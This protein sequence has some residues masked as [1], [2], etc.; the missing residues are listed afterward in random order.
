VTGIDVDIDA[1]V[2]ARAR[3]PIDPRIRQR[4]IAVQRDEGRR[5]LRALLW[6][7]GIAAVGIAAWGVTRSPL[8][9]VDTVVVRGGVHTTEADVVIASKLGRHPPM[10][11]VEPS[12]VAA[13]VEGLPWVQRARVELDWP[14][15]VKVTLL[16]RSPLAVVPA[17]PDKWVLL[18]PSGRVLADEPSAPPDLT[19]IETPKA[20]GPPAT[21]AAAPVRAALGIVETLPEPLAGRVPVVRVRD[22]DT[23]ELAL[24]NRVSVLLGPAG[25]DVREKLVALTTLVQKANLSRVAVIDVRV[26]TAPVLT[27]R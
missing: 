7:T 10:T 6:L 22:D 20:P 23:V 26:P 15:T 8:L 4:R 16:E 2:K 18:D 24:D 11:D 3:L 9:D 14:S 27:R 12:R 13:M 25:V 19:R 5:R 21:I 17:A 1:D